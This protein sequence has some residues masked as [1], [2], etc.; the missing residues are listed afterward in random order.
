MPM[1]SVETY[2]KIADENTS[3][4]KAVFDWSEYSAQIATKA[5]EIAETEKPEDNAIFV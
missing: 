2:N 5:A 1:C 4:R 3:T